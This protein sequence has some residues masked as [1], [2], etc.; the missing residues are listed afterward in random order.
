MVRLDSS[1]NDCTMGAGFREIAFIQPVHSPRRVGNQ[2]KSF[3]LGP[4]FA[5]EPKKEA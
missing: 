2:W 5:T 1:G 3:H 4:V